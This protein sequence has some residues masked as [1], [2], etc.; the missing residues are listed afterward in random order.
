MKHW[1]GAAAQIANIA[2]IWA[3]L[4]VNGKSFGPHPF[5]VQ[6]RDKKSH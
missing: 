5:I 6:I 2:I 1:I 3:Q 4:V